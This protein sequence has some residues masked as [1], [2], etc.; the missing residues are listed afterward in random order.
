MSNN[1][2]INITVH[3]SIEQVNKKLLDFNSKSSLYKCNKDK[4]TDFFPFFTL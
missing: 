1:K 4:G 3:I 2:E